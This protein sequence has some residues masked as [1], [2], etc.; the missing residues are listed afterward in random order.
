[1]LPTRSPSERGPFLTRFFFGWE[2]SP[3]KT[4]YR[5][6]KGTL[7]LSSLLEDLAYILD[8]IAFCS[9]YGLDLGSH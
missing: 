2:G 8:P 6:K 7:V 1:M 4:D 5:K 9:R 3:T